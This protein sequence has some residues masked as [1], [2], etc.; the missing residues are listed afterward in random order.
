MLIFMPI[1]FEDFATNLVRIWTFCYFFKCLV[2]TE[3][4][5]FCVTTL[6]SQMFKLGRPC[7]GNAVRRFEWIATWWLGAHPFRW[8]TRAWNFHA[9]LLESK[10][11]ECRALRCPIGWQKPNSQQHNCTAIVG[12]NRRSFWVPSFPSHGQW[13]LSS[14]LQAAWVLPEDAQK[15]EMLW[16]NWKIKKETLPFMSSCLFL[17]RVSESYENRL[18]QHNKNLYFHV[19]AG[20]SKE[21]FL[22]VPKLPFCQAFPHCSQAHQCL[23]LSSAN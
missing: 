1:I 19:L 17:H 2:D 9:M 16:C 15:I 7:D 13:N 8:T 10:R 20:F 12:V 3:L 14:W 21:L 4:D 18:G 23:V 11:R 6:G 5:C 22:S